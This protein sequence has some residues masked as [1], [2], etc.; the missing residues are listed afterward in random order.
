[1]WRLRQITLKGLVFEQCVLSLIV[2]ILISYR[3]YTLRLCT[4]QCQ[5]GWG[6]GGE[7]Q[8]IGQGFDRSIWPG[9]RAF[10]LCCC[11]GE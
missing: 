11:P 4:Y 2:V 3:G 5:A 6:G 9:G 1:M 8:D 7:R 10:E